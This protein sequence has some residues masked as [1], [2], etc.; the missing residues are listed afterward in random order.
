MCGMF[1]GGAVR[2]SA[3]VRVSACAC[4]VMMGV[5]MGESNVSCRLPKHQKH[6]LDTF[7][8]VGT[9]ALT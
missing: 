3:R 4:V 6:K 5:H 1:Q 7:T 2:V 9:R 8:N